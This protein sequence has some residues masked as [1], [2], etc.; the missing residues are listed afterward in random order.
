[1]RHKEN[2]G[3]AM[4]D[5]HDHSAGGRRLSLCIF[6]AAAVLTGCVPNGEPPDAALD[7]PGSYRAAGGKTDAAL[8]QLD[9]WRGFRSRELTALIEAAQIVNL[10]I[11]AASARIA[12]ADA[13]ARIAGAPLLPAIDAG[14]EASHSRRSLLTRGGNA[15]TGSGPREGNLYQASLSASYEVDFWG[16]N[17]ARLAAARLQATASRFDREVVALSTVASVANTF[18]LVLASQDRL[19]NARENARSAARV[20]GLIKQQLE[21][22]TTTGL[23][24]AQQ[25]ALLAQQ[26]ALIPTLTQ[27]LQQNT[28]AL[29]ILIAQPPERVDIRG[30]SLRRLAVPRVT[31]GLPSDLLTQRP[32][33]REA[34]TNLAAAN[35]NVYAAR[36][37]FLPS[38]QLTGQ[39][40]FQSAI[41]HSLFN[42]QA[43][44]FSLAAGLTQPIFDGGTL[45][46]NLEQQKGRR[47]E[48]LLE[49]RKAVISGFADVDIALTAVKQQAEFERLQRQVVDASRRAFNIAETRLREGTVDLITVL[50][51]QQTLFQAVDALVQARLAR[52]Q[53]IVSLYQ[54][55]GGGWPPADAEI[56]AATGGY[57]WSGLAVPAPK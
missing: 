21:V 3:P 16:K 12:Q 2:P 23:E 56:M 54:A 8:P 24:V 53:A 50:Q 55:L 17:R 49:Y 44:F 43:A 11:A 9:W 47:E 45:L 51:T 15:S 33:I 31:P 27:Q 29:A 26:R 28:A 25:E 35:A 4:Q 30:G 5:D 37:A 52:L 39:D 36:A 46:G 14:A 10:D 19:R 57:L 48:L 40:G 42:P 38:I 6:A 1:M 7:V 22:G 20:L 18:F 32:D 34:E 13:L 41:F